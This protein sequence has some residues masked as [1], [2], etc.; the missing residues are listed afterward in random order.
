MLIVVTAVTGYFYA[1]FFMLSKILLYILIS[2]VLGDFIFLFLFKSPV[3]VKR[4]VPKRMSNGDDNEIK[5]FLKNNIKWPLKLEIIDEIPYQF[6]QRNFIIRLFL[7]TRQ[8]KQLHYYLKPLRRG[9]YAFGYT[10]VFIHGIFRL[11]ARKIKMEEPVNV[12]VY[13]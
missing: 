5:I 10:I 6:Q 2:L 3:S 4:I 13:P 12:P 1:F 9:E 11:M 7:K 8:E